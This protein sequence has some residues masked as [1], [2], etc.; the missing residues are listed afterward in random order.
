MGT[1]S[2]PR[3]RGRLRRPLAALATLAAC[4]ALA[5]CGFQL[6]GQTNLP[7]D[8]QTVYVDGPVVFVDELETF[9]NG[10]GAEVIG[11]REEADAI[12]TLG[13]ER[14][15]RRVLS[16]DP[17]TGKDR[18]FELVYLVDFTVSRPDGTVAVGPEN[19]RLVRDFVFDADA[20]LGASRE[21]SVLQL[22]M[23]R[24]AAEELVRRIEIRLR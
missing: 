16:V 23:R 15:L 5:G 21:E 9:I 24:D 14:F 7:D 12:V 11:V 1:A 2:G 18:E 3:T 17:D 22:E 19:I 4:A 6:R 8:I 10:G 20:V 13:Q